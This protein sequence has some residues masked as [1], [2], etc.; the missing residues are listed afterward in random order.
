MA[1]VTILDKM[2]SVSPIYYSLHRAAK[3][4]WK[5]RA[6][7]FNTEI[8]EMERSALPQEIEQGYVSSA[9][10]SYMTP[11]PTTLIKAKWNQN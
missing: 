7:N 9:H 6:Y 3:H 1:T 8:F 11:R 2:T 4:N 5:C 10:F